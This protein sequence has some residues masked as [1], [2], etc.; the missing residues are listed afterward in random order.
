MTHAR[1]N[2]AAMQGYV[3]GEQ[4]QD[5][6]YIKLNTNENPY[7]P[8]PAVVQALRSFDPERLRL[9]PDPA[10]TSL[11]T[12]AARQAGLE[13]NWVICGNG[14]DDLLT[15]AVR[16]FVDQAGKLAF[17]LPTYS[18][19]PSLAQIQGAAHIAIPL[20]EDFGLPADVVAQAE[21]S[22]LLFIARPNAPTGNAFPLADMHQ[23]C[24][25]FKGIVWIDEAYAE[26][27]DDNCL[28]F[29][30]QYDNVVVSRTLSKSYSMAGVRLGIAYARPALI[31][32]MMKVKDSY[33]VN[34]LTQHL[35]LAALEDRTYVEANAARVRQSR[36]KLTEKLEAFGFEVLPS[37][38]NFIFT[39]PPIDAATYMQA[40][41]AE[42]ILI[43]YFPGDRT[44]RYVRI[45]IGTDAE[46]DA[47]VTATEKILGQ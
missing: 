31:E 43:R 20:T 8:S 38:A 37:Q 4:P 2:V 15:I 45:T 16:T 27:S 11:R 46:M 13:S 19:Y 30:R 41:R 39:T 36:Q 26:F 42:G 1:A 28:E 35:G 12:E 17:P 25:E 6:R 23:L 14:S 21:D 22:T 33:N 3:P 24:R 44:G 9:Y 34:M 29:V 32:E 7:P 47:L 5:R 18:L 40:L 10:C